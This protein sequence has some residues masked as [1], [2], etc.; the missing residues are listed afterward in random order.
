MGHDD[1]EHVQFEKRSQWR[2]WL[3]RHHASSPGAWVVTF[4]KAANKPSPSY[5]ELVLEALCF[6]WIDSKPGKV[7]DERTKLYF[8]PRKKGSGWAATNKARIEA[9]EAE[10]LMTPAG[11]AVIDQAKADGSWTK[12]DRSESAIV[13]PALAQAL[14]AYP[15][16]KAN[17]DAFPANVR[18][19]L[20]FWVD[21][22]KRDQ[23]RDRRAD[24]I[25]RLA[26]LGIRANQWTPKS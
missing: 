20:I 6:G 15:G 10:G 8:C 3:K 19:Q 21:D 9:L 11:R 2:A 18:K 14:A 25:A 5:E 4:K 1:A 16:S 26:Q 24:E 13:P 22:A 23:T 17:F 12:L 7:D